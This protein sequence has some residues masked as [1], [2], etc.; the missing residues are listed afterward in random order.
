VRF[1]LRGEGVFDGQLSN[2]SLVG[3][4]S[5]RNP[6]SFALK[7]EEPAEDPFGDAIDSEGP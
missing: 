5:G 1:E 4:V 7:R 2:D 3:S 6:G